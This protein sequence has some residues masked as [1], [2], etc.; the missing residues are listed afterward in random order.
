M[1]RLPNWL[2]SRGTVVFHHHL[3]LGQVF[4]VHLGKLALLK[5]GSI[6]LATYAVRSLVPGRSAVRMPMPWSRGWLRPKLTKLL[7][8]QETATSSG[9]EKPN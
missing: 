5:L 1:A 8:S 9:L 3:L 6:P 2:T 4:P 7:L